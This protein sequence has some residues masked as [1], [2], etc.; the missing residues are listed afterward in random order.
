MYWK[1]PLKNENGLSKKKKTNFSRENFKVYNHHSFC[2]SKHFLLSYTFINSFPIKVIL[3][4][5]D[6]EKNT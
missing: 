1:L 2:T 3:R 4:Q 6:A 5:I